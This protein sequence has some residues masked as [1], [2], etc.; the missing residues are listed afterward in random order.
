MVQR[1]VSNIQ[2]PTQMKQATKIISPS[3]EVFH[4]YGNMPPSQFS[5][6]NTPSTF[7]QNKSP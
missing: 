1:P 5:K 6:P 2:S 3:K 4:D 7:I